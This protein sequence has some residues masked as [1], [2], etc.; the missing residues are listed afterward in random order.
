MTPFRHML[1]DP[2]LWG[3]RRRWVVPAFAIGLFVAYLPFLGHTVIA[4][5]IALALRV[6]IPVAAI[7]SWA[8]NPA[9][10]VPMYYVAYRLGSF[11]LGTDVQPFEFEPTLEWMRHTFVHIW[12][13]LLLGSLLLGA[14]TAA[15]GY[16]VLDAIWRLSLA[17][18][19]KKKTQRAQ[20]LSLRA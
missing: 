20:R 17:S 19:K 2:R 1:Q 6:N 9:T 8:G 11:I 16:F 7:S 3:V 5:F 4:I 10:W 14:T 15:I 13:P 18:Y 12:Q